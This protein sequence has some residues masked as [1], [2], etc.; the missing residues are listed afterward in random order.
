MRTF[1]CGLIVGVALGNA[2]ATSAQQFTTGQAYVGWPESWQTLYAVGFGHGLSK[3]AVD[4]TKA[5][6]I[7]HCTVNWTQGQSD[8]AIKGYIANHPERG[9]A[10]LANLAWEALAES[11]N[12]TP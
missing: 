3:A 7:A 1:V 10:W 2:V 4:S 5:L 12:I 6:R 9:S 8:A 11:C